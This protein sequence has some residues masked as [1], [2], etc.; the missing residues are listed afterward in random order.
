M[1]RMLESPDDTR[2]VAISGTAGVGKTAFAV[3]WANRVA[4]RF[5]DGQVYIDLHGY[6]ACRPTDPDE[7][8][9]A[10]LR[11][12]VVTPGAVPS[13]KVDRVSLYRTLVAPRKMLI[14]LDNARDAE[15]V[16]DLLPGTSPSLVVVTSRDALSG[17]VVRLGVRRIVLDRPSP[18]DAHEL[19]RVHAGDRVDA[20]PEAAARLTEQCARL[21]LA[22][23][24]AAQHTRLHPT[25]TLS[26]LASELVNE[27]DRLRVLDTGDP[28]HSAR[29]VFSWSYQQLPPLAARMFRLWGVQPGKELTI[30][31]VAVLADLPLAVAQQTV[32]VLVRAHLVQEIA[33]R[34]YSMHDLLAIYAAEKV[35]ST[36]PMEVRDRAF[37]RLFDQYLLDAAAASRLVYP[38]EWHRAVE[39]PAAFADRTAALAWLDT[40]RANLVAIALHAAEHGL[41]SHAVRMSN[42]LHRYLDLCSHYGESARLHSAAA[43]VAPPEEL[44]QVLANHSVSLW[45]SGRYRE[46]LSQYRRALTLFRKTGH[47]WAEGSVLANIGAV[48]WRL[49]AYEE[50]LACYRLAQTVFSEVGDQCRVAYSIGHVGIVY[51]S[52]SRYEEALRQLTTAVILLRQLGDTYGEAGLLDSLALTCGR[53]K[54]YDT[55]LRY[56]A[57]ALTLAREIRD[58]QCEVELLNSLGT[59][60]NE[61]GLPDRALVRHQQA[62]ERAN[63]IGD[64]FERARAHDGIAECYHRL[65]DLENARVQWQLALGIYTTLGTPEVRSISAK[66]RSLDPASARV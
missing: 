25:R 33:P 65:G 3:H 13:A 34:R 48:T 56:F 20:E 4:D 44:G 50:A 8:V 39:A 11:R 35:R 9:S 15:H 40:E 51:A 28:H 5:P 30:A 12:L 14:L 2:L 22:L 37:T 45:R 19:L 41:A 63:R 24:I 55:A 53:L 57:R 49:G 58:W 32:D 16:R 6:E 38:H 1:D 64:R 36:D 17:L 60:I 18:E 29:A 27:H 66:L 59:T 54:Q 31:S 21:P 52:M 43:R 46:M 47:R 10:L 23:R 26:D 61:A 62:L 42:V 7:A